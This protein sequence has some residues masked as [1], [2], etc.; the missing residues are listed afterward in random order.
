MISN[1]IS[2]CLIR[3]FIVQ[4]F[5]NL[6]KHFTEGAFTSLLKDQKYEHHLLFGQYE[7][8]KDN[9]NAINNLA[10]NKHE[11]VSFDKID[12]SLV[13]FHEGDGQLFSIITNKNPKIQNIL[14]YCP[15]K[16]LNVKKEKKYLKNCLII[17]II[18][19]FNFFKN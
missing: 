9:Q 14:I 4:N 5:I 3:T 1:K 2:N 7:E 17:G 6:T 10:N 16:T 18:P 12:P 15:S 13:F 19:K 11:V 8:E